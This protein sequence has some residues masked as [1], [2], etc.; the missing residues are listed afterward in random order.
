MG[1][2]LYEVSFKLEMSFLIPVVMLIFIPI[3]AITMKKTYPTKA[4]DVFCGIAFVFVAIAFYLSIYSYA[5]A[6]SEV[7]DSYE[8][9]EY[10]IVEG[11]VENYTYG[12]DG[13]RFEINSVEFY[14]ND[15]RIQPGYN[16]TRSHGGVVKGNG[17]YLKIGYVFVEGY[18]NIIVYIEEIS[19][20]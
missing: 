5:N 14:Y 20:E 16:N 2:I 8:R 6:N 17:Q 3:F 19:N 7:M 4:I 13:E 10:E 18:G 15:Y 11:C 1:N 9:G 12:R